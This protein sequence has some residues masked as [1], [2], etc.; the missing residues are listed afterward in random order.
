MNK[1]NL[2]LLILVVSIISLMPIDSF[3]KAFLLDTNIAY[4]ANEPWYGWIKIGD[5]EI[6]IQFETALTSRNLS[7]KEFC[8]T[9]GYNLES[10]STII[11]QWCQQHDN[12]LCELRFVGIFL[13]ENGYLTRLPVLPQH[14]YY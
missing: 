4:A 9:Y 13:D 10:N 11:E 6:Q 12:S 2:R 1:Q 8:Q 3:R 7:V 14:M 5:E